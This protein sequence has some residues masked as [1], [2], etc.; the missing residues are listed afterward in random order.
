MD[1][2]TAEELKKVAM[3]EQPTNIP[4][5]DVGPVDKFEEIDNWLDTKGFVLINKEDKGKE[6][7]IIDMELKD[8]QFG[9]RVLLTIDFGNEMKGAF[10]GKT[11][12]REWKEKYGTIKGA[13]GKKVVIETGFFQSSTKG[14]VEKAFPKLTE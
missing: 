8:T 3:S 4:E 13:L 5:E 7:V 14:M 1:E 9:P 6:G 11:V 2:K 12:L 10:L